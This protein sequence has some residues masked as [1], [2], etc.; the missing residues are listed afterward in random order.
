MKFVD[1]LSSL[2]RLSSSPTKGMTRTETS[3]VVFPP[4]EENLSKDVITEVSKFTNYKNLPIQ[5]LET[6]KRCTYVMFIKVF[7]QKLSQIS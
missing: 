2:K 6:Y 7:K 3:S 1:I 5:D 4:I